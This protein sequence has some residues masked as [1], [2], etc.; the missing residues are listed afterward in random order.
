MFLSTHYSDRNRITLSLSVATLNYGIIDNPPKSSVLNNRVLII[1]A[2]HV[3]NDVSVPASSKSSWRPN[4]G[5]L[6][7]IL[8]CE[9]TR[10]LGLFV[11][12]RVD[13]R[14]SCFERCAAHEMI[15]HPVIK[16][17]VVKMTQNINIFMR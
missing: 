4:D 8:R 15:S 14:P 16:N 3:T 10:T 17:K 9:H 6:C 7:I 11:Y 1:F 2:V 5:I 12:C 13:G